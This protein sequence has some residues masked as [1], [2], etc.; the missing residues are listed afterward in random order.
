MN[1]AAIQD[2]KNIV[3]IVTGGIGRNIMATAVIRNLKKTYPDKRVIVI[4][5]FP[6][7]FLKN[8]H[9]HRLFGA[10]NPV[11]FY[12]D[13]IKDSQSVVLNVEPYQ[14]SDYIYKRKHFTECWAEM[15]GITLDSI[16]PEVFITNAELELAE[17]FMQRFDKD[18]VM[19]QFEGG[20][21]PEGKEDE[22]RLIARNAM[23]RRAIPEK[24]QKEISDAIGLLN[25]RVG[26]VAHENQYAPAGA[27]RISYPVRAMIALV[28]FAKQI[29]CVD[30][31]LQH[32]AAC[33]KKKAIVTWAGTS[34]VTLGYD[35]HVNLRRS[36]CDT[37]ECHRPNSYLFDI[38]PSG[39]QWECPW[40]NRCT[41]Y[42]AS[43]VLTEF[44]KITES[45][46]GEMRSVK[47]KVDIKVV[48]ANPYESKPEPCPAHVGQNG[49]DGKTPRACP[50]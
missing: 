20:K 28:P 9:I 29:V 43:D 33:F 26:V 40:S 49:S 19:C 44:E 39:Y 6:D 12:E 35:C 8:P 25:Y 41:E 47:S 13:Y 2:A 10:S 11:Y 15:C 4:A 31:F 37:P 30:S 50:T 21:V 42:A 27:D 46:H 3:F 45:K 14:H 1:P 36:V 48:G 17:A 22:K 18:L 32:A 24:I 38:E 7:I 16:Y 34:P 5:G 23:Y